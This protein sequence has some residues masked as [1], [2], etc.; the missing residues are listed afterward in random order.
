MADKYVEKF[1]GISSYTFAYMRDVTDVMHH[2]IKPLN[3]DFKIVGRAYTVKGP[4]IYLNAYESIPKGAVYVHAG[5]NE[6][7]GVW[8]ATFAEMYGKPRGLV[9]AVIDGGINAGKKTAEY[10]EVPTFARF[11]TPRPAINRKQGII[12]VPIVCGG[13]TVCPGDIVIGDADGIV[14]VPQRHE[15]EIYNHID[16]LRQAFAV[17]IGISQEPN[18][19]MSEHHALREVFAIKYDHP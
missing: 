10:K 17:F 11:V 14:I 13:V 6:E 4:D 8:S 12:Q 1:R 18:I 16:G 7:A 9:G 5:T 19:I 3:S 15:E 2:D